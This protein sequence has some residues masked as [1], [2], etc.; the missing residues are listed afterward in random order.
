MIKIE[1][2]IFTVTQLNLYIKGIFEENPILSSVT[3]K[4]EISN[5]KNHSTGHMYMSL[6]DETGD[7]RA[8]MFRYAASKLTFVPENGMKVIVKGRVAV[9]ERDGQYQVYIEQMQRDGLGEKHLAFEKLKAQLSKEGLFDVKYK[10]NLPKYPKRIGI[11][12]APTGAAI[13]DILNIL[14]R[15]FKFS[16]VVLYPVLVQGE[17]AASSIVEA[18][19]YFN[20][21]KCAD[22]LIVGRGGGSIEDLWAFNEEIVARAIFKSE[23]PV[24]S[25]VGH[26]IDFTISDFVADLR[27]PTPSAAAELVVP[28]QRELVEKFGNVLT[29]LNSCASRYIENRRL[30]LKLYS[31]KGALKNPVLKINDSRMYV[32]TLFKD[33]ENTYI[34]LF[35]EKKQAL[36]VA[37]SKLDSLSPLA[38]LTRGFSLVFNEEG[39]LLKK[40]SDLKSNDKI[41]V[42][43]SDGVVR[44]TVD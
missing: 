3:I 37:A 43:L 36:G 22:V 35:N 17:N 12:T 26:E 31:E 14:S 34:R 42:R 27:A 4:G 18:I 30:N 1:N 40:T 25:A 19:E 15:R 11:V 44:A 16:D 2:N 24:V 6:K 38:T 20:K 39:R 33:L 29:R 41:D 8:V 5:F 13:R 28:D 23:I 10:K 9:Y 7:V 32:D 21:S